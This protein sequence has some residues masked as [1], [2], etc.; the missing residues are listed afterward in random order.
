M[1][2]YSLIDVRL[3]IINNNTEYLYSIYYIT[4]FR[5]IGLFPVKLRLHTL[6]LTDVVGHPV[7]L[8]VIPKVV[9][10]DGKERIVVLFHHQ[11]VFSV[12]VIRLSLCPV[13]PANSFVLG[14]GF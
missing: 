6:L 7:A 9:P 10:E 2:C 1:K 12:L 13:K 4:G 5:L 3:K 8:E 14:E 11:A